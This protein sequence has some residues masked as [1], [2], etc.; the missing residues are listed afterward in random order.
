M[1]RKLAGVN[2]NFWNSFIPASLNLKHRKDQR[3]CLQQAIELCYYQRMTIRSHIFT[4]IVLLFLGSSPAYSQADGD[5]LATELENLRQQQHQLEGNIEQYQ[6][7]IALLRS[8]QSGKDA[9][10]PALEALKVQL[11]Q[12]QTR[13]IE[14]FEKEATLQEQIHSAPK[15]DPGYD[16]DAAD[17]ARLKTLLNN[18]YAEE[19]LAA[20]LTRADDA[21]T[22]PE[23]TPEG[24]APDKVRLSGLEGVATIRYMDQQLA[25]DQL[26]SPRRQ[27]DIIYH[28]EVRRDGELVSSGS[29]SLKSLG[30]SFYIG[31][32]SLRGGTAT[33][34]VRREEW[35]T[36]L[37]LEPENFYLV[38]LYLPRNAAPELHLVPVEELKAT[39]WREIPAWL[40]PIGALPPAPAAS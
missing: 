33:V 40:P 35:V 16:S 8:N 27:P 37:L 12:S 28:I 30:K 2:L 18:Y 38:T 6:T 20:A 9:S 3:R 29:H 25:A 23:S 14:L 11:I 32:V 24:Y 21:S 26:G 19:A 36:R 10:N 13:L 34:S 5:R 15:T 1:V 7:S 17:V 22:N 4:T 39:G 31:K